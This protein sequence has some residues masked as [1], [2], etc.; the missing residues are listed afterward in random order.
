MKCINI[1][2]GLDIARSLIRLLG[3][4]QRRMP[5]AKAPLCVARSLGQRVSPWSLYCHTLR[6]GICLVLHL[7]DTLIIEVDNE[8][9]LDKGGLVCKI[10]D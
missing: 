9:E 1:G 4:R 10:Q 8:D 3:I 5:F 7:L 2:I 6:L